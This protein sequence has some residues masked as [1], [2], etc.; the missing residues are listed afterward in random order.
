MEAEFARSISPFTSTILV[1]PAARIEVVMT[2]CPPLSSGSPKLLSEPQL[3]A[4]PG[5]FVADEVHHLLDNV[6]SP[7]AGLTSSRIARANPCEVRWDS[8]V[9]DSEV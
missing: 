4:F 1:V 3:I 6:S 9:Y 5:P 7:P 8:L 2:I